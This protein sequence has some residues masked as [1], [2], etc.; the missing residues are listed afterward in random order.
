MGSH[1]GL[2]LLLGDSLLFVEQEKLVT[3]L[4]SGRL[5][6][7]AGNYGLN[8]DANVA[9]VVAA[10]SGGECCDKKCC[11]RG[12]RSYCDVLHGHNLAGV[13]QPAVSGLSQVVTQRGAGTQANSIVLRSSAKAPCSLAE[14]AYSSE[15][16]ADLRSERDSQETSHEAQHSE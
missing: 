2:E 8:D 5:G 9:D 10:V 13:L 16:T 4:E 11:D 15:R 6:R 3:F 1:D 14:A 7:T 12:D